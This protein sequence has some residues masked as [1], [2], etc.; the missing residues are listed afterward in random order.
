MSTKPTKLQK[1]S[2]DLNNYIPINVNHYSDLIKEAQM[3]QYTYSSTQIIEGS[4]VLNSYSLID[5][6]MNYLAKPNYIQQ[7]L[8]AKQKFK[9]DNKQTLLN[10]LSYWKKIVNFI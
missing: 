1:L 10:E 9:N 5:I 8:Y 7:K 6:I 2:G 4:L 3:L